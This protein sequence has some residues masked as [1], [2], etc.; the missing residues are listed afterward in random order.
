MKIVVLEDE[1]FKNLE[2]ISKGFC[3]SVEKALDLAV[4]CGLAV[5]RV[6]EDKSCL[7]QIILPDYDI[8]N[9]Q[10]VFI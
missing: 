4:A 2:I 3:L 7:K 5:Y 1:T 10:S 9:I 6:H 8:V